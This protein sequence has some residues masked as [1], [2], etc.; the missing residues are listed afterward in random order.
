MLGLIVGAAAALY[1]LFLLGKYVVRPYLRMLRYVQYKGAS[2]VPF[3][4][5]IGAFKYADDSY[6]QTGDENYFSKKSFV[7]NP[8]ARYFIFNAFDKCFLLL[9]DPS[10]LQ[11]F[12]QKQENY[13]KE[14]T[15]IENKVR[16]FGQGVAFS[17]GHEWSKRRKIMSGIFHFSFFNKFIPKINDIV[18]R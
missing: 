14:E 12:F 16:F 10:L 13:V 15:F 9:V 1:F 5:I 18:D 17:E 4:P 7:D 11:E 6:K 3:F 8:D 2:W